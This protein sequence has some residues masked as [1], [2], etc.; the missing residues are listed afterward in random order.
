M[1]S[2]HAGTLFKNM[3]VTTSICAASRA[4]IFTGLWERTHRYTFLTPPLDPRY[5]AQSYP[6]LMR[7]AGYKVA[8]IGKLGV[9][10]AQDTLATMFD[11]FTPVDR[12]PY[13]HV[14]PDGTLIHETD[15]QA[16]DAIAFLNRVSVDQPFCL[17]VSFNAVHEEDGDLDNLYPWPP[18]ADG[19]Y[20]DVTIPPPRLSDPAIFDALPQFL[21]DSANRQRWYWCCDSYDKYEKN[22]RAYFRMISGVDNAIGRVLKVLADRGLDRETIIVYAADNG[23]YMG[24]RG[25]SGKWSHYEQSLRVPLIVADP[26]VPAAARG[27]VE[28]AMA[29]NVDLPATFLGLAGI[30][31]P[32]AMEGSDLSAWIEGRAAGGGRTDFFCEHLAE[33]PDIPKWQGVRDQ[34]YV[35]ARYFAEDPAYEFLHDL[36]TDPDE[37]INFVA[38]PAYSAVLQQLRQRCDEL[39][40]AYDAARLPP[41]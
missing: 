19:M 30:A 11:E 16:N 7:Q 32:P 38:D 37:L 3:F 26:R 24:D 20:E 9:D 15:E 31:K 6:V 13:F 33:I 18:S 39:A 17:N 41:A 40:A 22:M 35:Y 5:V 10:I 12:T 25:F 36:Q 29:L 27:K 28:T 4:S 34:R 21:K 2:R 14:Q 8:F 23:F 1:R